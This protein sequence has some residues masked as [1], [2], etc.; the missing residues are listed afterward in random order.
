MQLGSP[1]EDIGGA[2]S[3]Y[4]STWNWASAGDVRSKNWSP[5]G[6]EAPSVLH[7]RKWEI[8]AVLMWQHV[9]CKPSHL[10]FFPY[11][12]YKTIYKGYLKTANESAILL[13][14]SIPH[15]RLK[16]LQRRRLS[17]QARVH[18]LPL[19]PMPQFSLF[20][21][22]YVAMKIGICAI[23][24]LFRSCWLSLQCWMRLNLNLG[25]IAKSAVLCL[26]R[27]SYLKCD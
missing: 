6:T 26:W 5:T 25:C 4:N 7:F 1:L 12:R 15:F 10:C 23:V 17:L 16:Q 9:S 19:N 18:V 14:D 27:L 21:L 8:Q 24:C 11:C 2:N 20:E 13:D 3:R 22:L